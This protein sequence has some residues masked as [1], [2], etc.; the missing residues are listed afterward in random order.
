MEPTERRHSILMAAKRVF[1]RQ[2]YHAAGVA[3]I[4]A[5]AGIARGTF[6]L[7]FKSKREI[8]SSLLEHIFKAVG[9]QLRDFPKNEPHQILQT[10]LSN[11]ERIK[12]FFFQ[13]PDLAKILIRESTALDA[14]SSERL[15]EIR[16]VLA[17]RLTELVHHWQ[18]IGILRPLDPQV[19]AYGII[20]AVKELIE[21]SLISGN[22]STDGGRITE[23]IFEVFLF[24]IVSPEHNQLAVEHIEEIGGLN[25][26]TNKDLT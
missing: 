13:D 4:I 21:Q 9:E 8:F 15:Q 16:R 26:G 23:E 3:D 20:G 22:L 25:P 24:G 5:E 10:I 11:V 17:I 7:Y 18:K 12:D 6:Y 19:I 2:G 1:A 14:D